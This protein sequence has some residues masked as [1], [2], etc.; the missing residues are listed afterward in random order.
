MTYPRVDTTYLSEDLHPKVPKI[1]KNLQ[2]YA[3]LIEPL[4]KK[5]IAKSKTI[6]NDKK[7][8]DHHAIIPTGINGQGLSGFEE[9]IYDLICRRFIAVFYPPCKVSNTTILGK[10]EKLEFKTSGKQIIDPGWRAIY[11]EESKKEDTEDEEDD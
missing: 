8:T 5:P 10:V 9:K 4:M 6:F 3:L 11:Q 7:I 1:L 2:Q